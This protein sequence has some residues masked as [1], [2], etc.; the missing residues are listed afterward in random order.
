M[1]HRLAQALA[2]AHALPP[3]R[4]RSVGGVRQRLWF[5]WTPAHEALL[6]LAYDTRLG[7]A[8]RIPTSAVNRQR[9]RRGILPYGT[10]PATCIRWTA[11]MLRDL[12]RLTD[13]AFKARHHV[14]TGVIAVKRA[15]LGI[16]RARSP[17]T[18]RWTPRMLRWLGRRDDQVVAARLGLAPGTVRRARRD[19]GIPPAR[20]E[21]I[22]WSSPSIRR[23]LGSAPDPVIARRLGVNAKH[24]QIRRTELGIPPFRIS[25]R[26]AAV[27]ARLGTVPDRILAEELGLTI[28]AIRYYRQRLGIP[29]WD[30]RQRP[31]TAPSR[32]R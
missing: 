31:A 26:V 30:P 4:R 11:A 23:L 18:V 19:R 25:S 1:R 13:R 32:R 24:L 9:N 14:S 20:R 16:A 22:P 21:A 15:A 29:P 3:I 17:R 12:G 8:W 7:E 6:G 5:V 2:A 10:S 27:A 28:P